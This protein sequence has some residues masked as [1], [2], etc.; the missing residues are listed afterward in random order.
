[1]LTPGVACRSATSCDDDVSSCSSMASPDPLLT[2]PLTEPAGARSSIS[3]LA[4]ALPFAGA[5]VDDE[6][7]LP[8]AAVG[9]A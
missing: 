2:A 9:V 8:S 3:R 7:D 5:D 4:D 6:N 1:M